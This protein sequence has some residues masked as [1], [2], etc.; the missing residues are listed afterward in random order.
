M[1]TLI[2]TQTVLTAAHSIVDSNPNS[3]PLNISGTLVPVVTNSY[4]PTFASMYTVT[5]GL[6][7]ITDNSTAQVLSVSQ[8]IPV[9]F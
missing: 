6:H 2:D 7:D 4:Y 5:L 9:I 8:L 3:N 1:G